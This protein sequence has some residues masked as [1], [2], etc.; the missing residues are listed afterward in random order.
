MRAVLPDRLDPYRLA[1]RGARLEGR[2]ALRTMER[3]RPLLADEPGEAEVEMTFAVD[4]RGLH[5]VHG[6]VRAEVSM[7]CQRCLEPVAVQ[8]DGE[9]DLAVVASATEGRHLPE[10]LEP[11]DCGA[12]TV[13]TA[14][15]IEDE[16]LLGLPLV[17][18]HPDPGCSRESTRWQGREDDAAENP[19]SV[20]KA[21]QDKRRRE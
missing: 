2:V 18:S 6:R 10:G 12:G 20:L 19:F 3:L 11:L 16:I 14:G 15:L 7:T 5:T 21:W 1:E 17:P 4:D 9:F 13:A 8:V